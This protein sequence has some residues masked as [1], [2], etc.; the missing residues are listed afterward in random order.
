MQLYDFQPVP[1][2][3]GQ[4]FFETRHGLFYLVKFGHTPYLLA[5]APACAEDVYELSVLLPEPPVVKVPSDPAVARTVL[6]ICE[7]F[8]AQIGHPIFLFI[9]DSHDGRQAV[10]ART[11]ARWFADISNPNWLK[12]DGTLPDDESKGLNYVS[13]I[14][15]LDHPHFDKATVAFSQLIAV[16]NRPK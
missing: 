14:I 4:F 15:Q 13:L 3:S 5:T 10:R 9:C 1:D 12:M 6:A 7:L 16:Y 11:F 2:E 8:T